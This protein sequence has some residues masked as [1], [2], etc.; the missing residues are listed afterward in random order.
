MVILGPLFSLF[1]VSPLY[2]HVVVLLF[3]WGAKILFWPK[4]R[5]FWPFWAGILRPSIGVVWG[6]KNNFWG[7]PNKGTVPCVYLGEP[8]TPPKTRPQK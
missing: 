5:P 7:R 4:N 3:I 2:T 6:V 1:F 8:E